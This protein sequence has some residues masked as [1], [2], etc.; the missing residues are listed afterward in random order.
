MIDDA[1]CAIPSKRKWSN[2]SG[3][4]SGEI[5]SLRQ[6]NNPYLL[7]Y[8]RL[9]SSPVQFFLHLLVLCCLQICLPYRSHLVFP[10]EF[11]HLIRLFQ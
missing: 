10:Y 6:E 9:E 4:V 7:V 2:V 8:R 11:L 1:D 5:D 3:P